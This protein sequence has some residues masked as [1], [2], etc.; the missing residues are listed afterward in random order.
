MI[1][2]DGQVVEHGQQHLAAELLQALRLLVWRH[3]LMFVV[4]SSPPPP[5]PGDGHWL[6]DTLSLKYNYNTNRVTFVITLSTELRS[7]ITVTVAM[8]CDCTD[9]PR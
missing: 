9:L 2:A 6:T 8:I 7:G 3:P 5:L 4:T 1:V